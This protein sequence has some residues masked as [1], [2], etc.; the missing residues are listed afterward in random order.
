MVQVSPPRPAAGF[1]L[2]EL[3]IALAVAALL[4]AA[5]WPHFAD[6]VR[7]G[8]RADALRAATQVQ[9]AQ[10]RWLGNQGRYTDRLADLGL[11]AASP[12]GHYAL[13]LSGASAT[14]Y[15]LTV[16]AASGGAQAADAGCTVLTVS[17]QRGQ[18]GFA[19]A[20]CWGP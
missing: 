1:T 12:A 14:A 2:V 15:T 16:S 3:A 11:G 5:A 8:R 7:K 17:V 10:E 20:G 18:A 4:A 13:A 9:Q 6:S 19:P